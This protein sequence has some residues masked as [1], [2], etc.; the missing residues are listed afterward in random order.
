MVNV[1]LPVA[2]RTRED[3]EARE[4]LAQKKK[5]VDE[6]A[7]DLR[8]LQ[9]ASDTRPDLPDVLTAAEVA[10]MLRLNL[11]TFYSRYHEGRIPG[12]LTEKPLRFSK[13]VIIGWIRDGRP[14]VNAG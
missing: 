9:I 14:P 10:K 6:L 7:A 2:A 8:E 1:P 5:F 3:R 11:K 13:R 4:R 12:C